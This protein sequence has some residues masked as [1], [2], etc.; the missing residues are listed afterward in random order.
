MPDL[1][2]FND[3]I[4]PWDELSTLLTERIA[5][6]PG[7]S[8]VTRLAS[9]LAISIRHQ[10]D[11]TKISDRIACTESREHALIADTADFC[12]HGP[13]RDP[14]RNNAFSTKA[15]FEYAPNK[16]FSFIRNAIIV[17]HAT[18]GAHDFM[19]ASLAAI[20]YWIKRRGITTTWAGAVRENA[21]EFHQSAR[22]KYDPNR[23]IFMEQI[24]LG[25]FLRTPQGWQPV[26][27][28]EVRFEVY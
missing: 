27:P 8:D 24:R 26:D 10:V 6:Q 1:R 11:L 14:R 12:K 15:L 25:F 3:L 13:L 9:S 19:V 16:G 22:L 20:Q 21:Q 5:L 28:P 2:F 23:C 18:Y 17:E 4:K 7:L